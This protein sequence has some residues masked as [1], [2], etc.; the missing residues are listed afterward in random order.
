MNNEKLYKA[1]LETYQ[2]YLGYDTLTKGAQ[3]LFWDEVNAITKGKHD[4][5]SLK[6]LIF[7]MQPQEVYDDIIKKTN[8]KIKI[9]EQDDKYPVRTLNNILTNGIP[10]IKWRIKNLVPER[11]I[12][13]IGGLAGTFKTW[14]AMD[15][16]VCCASGKLFLDE[17]ETEKCNVL[18]LDEENGDIT[19]PY[20][21]NKLINGHDSAKE[22]FDNLFISMFNNIKVDTND[23]VSTLNLLIEKFQP[24]LVI[25]DSMVR[26]MMGEE[27]KSKDVRIVFDNLKDVFKKYQDLSFVL[28]HH[29]TKQGRGLTSLR[30]SGDFAAFADV[31]LMFESSHKG[32]ASIEMAKNRHV[33]MSQIS[34]FSFQISDME[35]KE[36]NKSINLH[37][38]GDQ[39]ANLDAVQACIEDMM[40]WFANEEITHTRTNEI[41]KKMS[42]LTHKR[43]IIYSAIKQ[44]LSNDLISKLK[45]GIYIINSPVE[46]VK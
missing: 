31:I 7:T 4:V 25:I 26:C 34:N 27:D 1:L 9:P 15:M 29:T 13:I 8:E 16:A 3:F 20:R 5:E 12:T 33:D 14:A 2:K 30:G 37:Y 11:G 19:L 35:D 38:I 45:R 42:K 46:S 40:D 18:Y 6:T 43:S 36:G 28:L 21:F 24:K 23:T 41:Y 32:F 17:F 39:S 22:E 44:M 10:E